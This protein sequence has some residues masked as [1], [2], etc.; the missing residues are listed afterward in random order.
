[1][2]LPIG[3][4]FEVTINSNKLYAIM[5]DMMRKLECQETRIGEMVRLIGSAGGSVDDKLKTLE[6]ALLIELEK[7]KK[8]GQQDANYLKLYVRDVDKKAS[9]KIAELETAIA[10]LSTK[11]NTSRAAMEDD[12]A[13]KFSYLE[14]KISNITAIEELDSK[15]TAE[16]GKITSKL[17]HIEEANQQYREGL[18]LHLKKHAEINENIMERLNRPDLQIPRMDA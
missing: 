17:L 12:F 14:K 2:E 10:Q 3:N 5:D 4:F 16:M 18:D 6:N 1:M 13:I 8:L 9:E 15:F 11:I 7:V